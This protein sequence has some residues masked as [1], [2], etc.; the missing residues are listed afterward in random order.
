AGSGLRV[1]RALGVAL[2]LFLHSLCGTWFHSPW[3]KAVFLQIRTPQRVPL[4]NLTQSRER[5][6]LYFGEF[7]PVSEESVPFA[8]IHDPIG[9]FFCNPGLLGKFLGRGCVDNVFEGYYFYGLYYYRVCFVIAELHLH[10]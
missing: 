8:V 5:E 9:K 10:I 1:E 6:L 3:F 7:F 4:L 2:R